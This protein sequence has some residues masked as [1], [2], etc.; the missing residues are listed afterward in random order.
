MAD[1]IERFE[2]LTPAGTTKSAPLTTSLSFADGIVERL[3]VLVPPGPRGFAGFKIRHS[4]QVIIPRTGTAWIVSDNFTHDWKLSNY[5]TGDKWSIQTHN[6]DVFDHTIYLTFHV[7]EIPKVMFPL[8]N[9]GPID[10]FGL[11]QG[12]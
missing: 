11:V 8:V 1:R 6:T 7:N 5:P 9:V 4:Q 2:V 10:Q 3:E 12:H